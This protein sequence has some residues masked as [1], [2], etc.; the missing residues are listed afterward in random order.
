MINN[1]YWVLLMAVS[2][3]VACESS[4]QK[5]EET[6]LGTKVNFVKRGEA[7]GLNDQSILRLNMKFTTSTGGVIIETEDDNPFFIEYREDT[8][9]VGGQFQ[10]VLEILSVG[11]S[12]TFEIPASD[13][14]LKTF[15]QPIVPDSIDAASLMKF[16]VGVAEQLTREQFQERSRELQAA[17]AAKQLDIENAT[18]DQY[19]ADNNVTATT[20]ESGLRYAV[21]EEGNGPIPE[22][23]QRVNVKY[24]GRFM[25][26]GAQFDAGEYAFILGRGEVIRGWDEGISYLPVGTKAVL[27]IPSPLAYGRGG[28]G[29]PPNSILIFDVEVLEIL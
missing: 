9:N 5:M 18:I 27:Y 11:D 22:Q 16:E 10:S 29:I 24:A 12:C 14:F 1:S 6:D 15:R 4:S 2:I 7:D 28:R 20:T 25:E 21:L 17:A 8:A 19:L 13:V 23:G 26:S 3:L